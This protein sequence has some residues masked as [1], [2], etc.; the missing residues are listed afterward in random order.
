[1]SIRKAG[2]RSTLRVSLLAAL[3][4]AG[5]AAGLLVVPARSGSSTP[6]LTPDTTFNGGNPVLLAFPEPAGAT[7]DGSMGS[8]AVGRQS[9]GKVI[10]AGFHF[11]S[12]GMQS[13]ADFDVARVNANGTLDTTFGTNG[14]A[15]IDPVADNTN[16]AFGMVIQPDDKIVVVGQAGPGLGIARLTADGAPDPTFGTNGVIADG[17]KQGGSAV[18][19]DANGNLDV[20]TFGGTVLRYTSTGAVDTSFGTS[21]QTTSVMTQA[22][23]IAIQPDGKIVIA[24]Q[25]GFSP[26]SAVVARFKSDGSVDTGFGTNG[27]TN[28][29]PGGSDESLNSVALE[30]TSIVVGGQV[31]GGGQLLARLTSAGALDSTFGTGG[32][33]VN[34]DGSVINAILYIPKPQIASAGG[35]FTGSTSL[36]VD[37]QNDSGNGAKIHCTPHPGQSPD[38][39]MTQTCGASSC[40]VD[41]AGQDAGTGDASVKQYVATDTP[42]PSTS[43]SSTHAPCTGGFDPPPECRYELAIDDVT[44][45]VRGE[46]SAPVI[47]LLSVENL[48][49]RNS[50]PP[51]D[52]NDVSAGLYFTAEL[53]GPEGSAGP[54]FPLV[55]S[56]APNDCRDV[57]AII[58][59][60]D[61]D[62]LAPRTHENFVFAFKWTKGSREFWEAGK[63]SVVLHLHASVAV[64]KC[65]GQERSCKNNTDASDV[66]IH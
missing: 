50:S 6:S 66:R 11:A 2:S 41:V 53:Q 27:A 7:T 46:S 48:D 61:V 58:R 24:G 64:T 17:A 32:R 4:A 21:G 29:T 33:V 23:G 22:R 56:K 35:A 20:A 40:T 36:A 30:Q 37:C 59:W 26:A 60:C 25:Q 51:L 12:A 54:T 47:A 28:I 65:H 18:A 31:G 52:K 14:Y 55:F 5:L 13:F 16:L 8:S 3:G 43:S 10:V 1:M 38:Q 19:V 34:T 45:P 57:G 49:P 9:T 39:A 44:P 63:G 62:G 15:A 42:P